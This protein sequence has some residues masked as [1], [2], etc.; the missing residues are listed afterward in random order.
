MGIVAV[1]VQLQLQ[2]LHTLTVIFTP[3]TRLETLKTLSSLCECTQRQLP[4]PCEMT[5][6]HGRGAGWLAL[7]VSVLL[8]ATG[9]AAS[10]SLVPQSGDLLLTSKNKITVSTQLSLSAWLAVSAHEF[11]C[12]EGQQSPLSHV[13][14]M[15]L[16]QLIHYL[17]CLDH[18]CTNYVPVILQKLIHYVL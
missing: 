18:Y 16:Q 10:T 5:L 9:A 1:N 2:R 8:V 3:C 17:L 4:S 14:C 6:G 15:M 12:I 7:V 11:T 13:H